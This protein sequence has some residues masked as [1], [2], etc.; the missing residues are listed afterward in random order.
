M[1]GTI[2]FGM[3]GGGLGC[4]QNGVVKQFGK[5]DGL[6]SSSVQCLHASTN[7]TLW[8]GTYGGGLD[9]FKNGRFT[10]ITSHEGLP[11]NY[12]CDIEE[13]AQG[14]LWISSRGGVFRVTAKSLEDFLAGR[15]ASVRVSPMARPARLFIPAS[16]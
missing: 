12:L 15:S 1:D 10:K 6:S 7:G 11:D 4:L 3:I 5:P 14:N 13:D 8:I 9:Y 16:T 2:W